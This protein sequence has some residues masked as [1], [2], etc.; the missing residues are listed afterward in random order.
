[1][2]LDDIDWISMWNEAAGAQKRYPSDT[3]EDTKTRWDRMA[4]R[5]RKW[6]DVDDY[7]T[8]L[9]EKIRIHEGWSALDVGCGTGAISIPIA[10]KASCVTALDISSEMLKILSEDAR[11]EGLSNISSVR[12]SWDDVIVGKDI[13]PHDIVIASRSIGGAP[14][15]WNALEK[16]DS[17][18]IR[19]VYITAWGGGE[20]GHSKGINAVLG[21]PCVD[22]P[23]YVYI[24]NILHKMGIRANI[25][26]LQC[27]SRLIY[28]SVDDAVESSTRDIGPLNAGELRKVREFLNSSL[29]KNS[30]GTVE[31]PDNKPV[32][33]LLWW[34]KSGK[35]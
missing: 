1:M 6:M 19:Y 21:R 4:P 31:V 11:R 18:A 2:R 22:T 25:E 7:P 26:H 23:D 29:V 15:V 14:D 30:D 10:K 3:S 13:E 32:W 33:S 9:L 34:K 28:D 20:R 27:H 16:A 35:K 17:A 24:F 12:I 5:F 8:L